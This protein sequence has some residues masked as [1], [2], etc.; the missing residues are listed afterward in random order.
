MDKRLSGDEGGV[1]GS[2]L[3]KRQSNRLVWFKGS[4]K[5]MMILVK[6]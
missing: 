2:L 3:W 6:L 4:R 5:M 1:R